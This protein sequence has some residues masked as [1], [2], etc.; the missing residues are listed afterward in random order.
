[1]KC[2]TNLKTYFKY[3]FQY[4]NCLGEIYYKCIK[5]VPI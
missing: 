3:Q 1:M 5:Y 2:Y 4:C